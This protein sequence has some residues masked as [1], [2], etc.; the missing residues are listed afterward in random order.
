MLHRRSHNAAADQVEQEAA[1]RSARL[2]H[3]KE[4]RRSREKEETHEVNTPNVEWGRSGVASLVEDQGGRVG[5]L[6][7]AD[8][9]VAGADHKKAVRVTSEYGSIK[10]AKSSSLGWG[11]DT[12]L[13][14]DAPATTGGTPYPVNESLEQTVAFL[15]ESLRAERARSEEA[16]ARRLQVEAENLALRNELRAAQDRVLSVMFPSM[17]LS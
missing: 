4:Q 8:S 6:N 10:V 16:E 3:E 1:A 17:N 2:A 13:S 7:E 5:V 12:P 14:N 15:T 9:P 11:P